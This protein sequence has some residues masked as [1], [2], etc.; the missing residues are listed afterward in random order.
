MTDK[1][2]NSTEISSTV[3]KPPHGDFGGV[4]NRLMSDSI[5]HEFKTHRAPDGAPNIVVVM[6]DDVGFGSCSTFGGPV[7]TPALQRVADNGLSYNQFHT[8]ALCSPTRAALVTGRNHHAAHM[9]GIPEI[10]NSFPA[11]DSYIPAE[12]ASVAEV[13]RQA[14]YN[15]GCFGKWHLT[16]MAEQS[17]AGPF[18]HW[19]TGMG[20]ERFYGILGAESSQWDP[21]VYDQTTPVAPYAGR[22]DYHLTEDVAEK[23][24]EWIS[25]QKAAAPD[26]PFLCYLSP[27]AVHAPHH[28]A[29]EWSDKFRGQFDNGWDA[30]RDQ[31]FEQQI[32]QGIIPRGTINTP[33]PSVLPSWDEYPDRYKPVASRMMEVFAGFLAHTDAQIGRVLDALEE[34]GIADN[35]L[36][37]YITGDNGASTEGGIHGCWSVPAYQNGFPEDPEWLLEH[38]EDLGTNRCEGHYNAGWAWALDSPFQ[39]MKQIAS[40]F[41]GT[42]NAMAVSW[43]QRMS[44][45]G[46]LRTQFHHVTDIAPTLL[47]AAGIVAPTHVNGVEQLPLDGSSLLYTF[48]DPEVPSTNTTQY[49]EMLGNRAMY[50]E[51]WIAS[52]YHGGVPW[53]RSQGFEFDTDPERWELYDI[54]C[55]FSQS[56]DLADEHPEKLAELVSLFEEQARTRGVYPLRD[57]KSPRTGLYGIPDSTQGVDKVRYTTAHVNLLESSV[58]NLKNVSFEITAEIS[59]SSARP[60]GVIASQGGGMAGWSLYLDTDSRPVYLYNWL[61][62]ELT[63]VSGPDPVGLGDNTISVTYV[64]DGGM[65][66]GGLAVLRVNG[67]EVARKRIERTVP[68][69]FSCNQTFSVGIDT[70]SPV[71][72]YRRNYSCTAKVRSVTLE[73][74]SNLDPAERAQIREAENSAGLSAH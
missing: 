50:H 12:T 33:R 54:R 29:P 20:F 23:A 7:P 53:N 69:M 30:L 47:E 37:V 58:I 5:P 59:V 40:H 34:E 48:D 15:T 52:C 32:D 38:I 22:D 11:Y 2:N 25:R 60:Q 3:G 71:G 1:N 49:F 28:V 14:G 8:T 44:Q 17:A 68:V 65:G 73:R 31:I 4:I 46:G 51:G 35:T 45:G 42:R 56:R 21:I 9:G 55:D 61:G 18:D 63:Y 13:L 27:G 16:P 74:L 67:V 57:K 72:P 64:H 41:G 19:P 62:H 10:A 24:I 70:G 39:W 43:P 66:A 36:F 26:R 6:L